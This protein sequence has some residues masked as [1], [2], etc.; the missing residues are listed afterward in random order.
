MKPLVFVDRRL[1]EDVKHYLEQHCT[2]ITWKPDEARSEQALL[3]YLSEAEGYFTSGSMK[4]NDAMLDA[5]PKLK[6]VSSMSVGYNHFDLAAMKARHIIGTH[7]PY[8]L[9]DTVADLVFGLMLSCSRRI[10]ELDRYIRNGQWQ[11][12]EGRK[13]FGLDVHHRKLGI[14]GM[15]RIGEAVA[16]RA[17]YGFDMKVSY[18]ARSRK[19]ELEQRMDVSYES[20]D[21]LL[22]SS[23]FIV[24]LTPLTPATKGLIGAEQFSRMQQHAIFINASRGATVDEQA[25]IEA[26]QTGKIAGAGLDVFMQEPLP[27]DHPFMK[28]DQVVMTPHIGSATDA[29]R[30]QMAMLAAR[31]L[32]NA[33]QGSEDVHIVPELRP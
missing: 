3:H 22:A 33:L 18:Y 21:Q 9:D 15:G 10:A 14:I 20:L 26:L 1:P 27:L 17:L 32:V 31:N 28:L 11:G 16:K 29:T 23:D 2:I 24:L 4:I 12:N 25:L 19:P 13:L 30:Q 6:V 5:A 7:T 8:I